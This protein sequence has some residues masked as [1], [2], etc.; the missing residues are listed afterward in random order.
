MRTDESKKE[1]P[2]AMIFLTEIEGNVKGIIYE[3]HRKTTGM[4][5][6]GQNIPEMK[7]LKALIQ[8]M[9]TLKAYQPAQ[10]SAEIFR[11]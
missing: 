2:L 10:S 3:T 5:S 1:Y 7:S 6:R 11:S 8:Q 9:S 4:P